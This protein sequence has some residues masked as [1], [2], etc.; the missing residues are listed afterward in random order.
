MII[1]KPGSD[2]DPAAFVSLSY[3]EKSQCNRDKQPKGGGTTNGRAVVHAAP[4]PLFVLS[5]RSKHSRV[6]VSHA[7]TAT[8]MISTI[9]SD[10]ASHCG[11]A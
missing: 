11:F 6:Y 5:P 8:L 10:S 9:E 1:V 2:E 7:N 4:P 3:F